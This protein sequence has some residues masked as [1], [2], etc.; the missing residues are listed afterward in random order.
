MYSIK[1]LILFYSVLIRDFR[2][3]ILVWIF[4]LDQQLSLQSQY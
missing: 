3:P 2:N 4:I 1:I